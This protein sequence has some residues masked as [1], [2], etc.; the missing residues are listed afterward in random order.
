MRDKD[1]LSL[2]GI[3]IIFVIFIYFSLSLFDI[4]PAQQ[5][6]YR[7]FKKED[8]IIVKYN[9]YI[10]DVNSFNTYNN[11]INEIT[12]DN[13]GF[14]NELSPKTFNKTPSKYIDDLFTKTEVK[15]IPIDTNLSKTGFCPNSKINKTDMPLP[16]VP[17]SY[18]LDKT[19]SV[20]LSEEFIKHSIS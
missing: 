16:N 14:I 6:E 9:D 5:S 10:K 2:F 13:I 8:P 12:T 15:D 17:M 11:E 1:I 7:F 4:I 20:K 19:K 18:I 3:F